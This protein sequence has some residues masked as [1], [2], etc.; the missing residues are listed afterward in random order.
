MRRSASASAVSAVLLAVAT[1]LAP[2]SQA[3]MSFGNYDVLTNRYT[4]A[5]WIWF[6]SP[7]IPERSADCVNVAAR[8]VRK[9]YAYYEGKAWLANGRY[10]LTVDQPDG[11]QCPLGGNLPTRDTYSWDENTLAGTIDSV[12]DVG[13][14]NGPPGH[15]FWTFAVQRL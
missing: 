11:L 15:Q 10:T 1:L 9:Y 14:F 2:P 12:Y 5:P 13:C 4:L 8:P 7:C 6:V 3:A